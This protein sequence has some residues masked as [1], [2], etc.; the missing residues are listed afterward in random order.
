MTGDLSA[1]HNNELSDVMDI[2]NKKARAIKL[3][4]NDHLSV[5]V[6]VDRLGI[7][8]RTVYRWKRGYLLYGPSS[9][10]VKSR[11]PKNV[12]N[13][14]SAVAEELIVKA[15]LENPSYGS[16]R[17]HWYLKDSHNIEISYRTIQRILKRR[18]IAIRI[19]PKNTH[20]K[21]FEGRH[22]N[23]LWQID[24][25]QFRIRGICKVYIFA[26]IDDHSRFCVACEIFT[27]K[28]AVN[29]LSTLAAAV[30][31]YGKPKQLLT[32]N[33]KEVV[34]SVFENYLDKRKIKHIRC[35]SYTPQAKGKMERFFGILYRELIV[36]V[37]FVSVEHAQQEIDK[38]I[39]HYNYERRHGGIGWT[40]PAKRYRVKK[41][42]NR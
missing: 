13:K 34:E 41:R 42:N 39:H 22:P 33:G 27:D 6:I 29:S 1:H 5:E 23:S 30:G 40:Q 20:T 7:S 16:R 26:I 17:L 3:A 35:K 9:F 37:T 19:K 36:K 14:T 31:K 10:V 12:S 2:D 24:A 21:R 32:D 8:E 4:F 25:F 11:R 38:F 18:G 28:E 15:K